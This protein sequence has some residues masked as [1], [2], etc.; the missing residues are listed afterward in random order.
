MYLA[1]S[2]L[3]LTDSVT[4]I[5]LPAGLG[6]GHTIMLSEQGDVMLLHMRVRAS[7]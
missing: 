1:H 4:T 5:R 2:P 7:T 6:N 3:T